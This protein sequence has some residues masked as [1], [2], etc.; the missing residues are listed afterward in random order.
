MGKELNTCCEHFTYDD[1]RYK[2]QFFTRLFW[3]KYNPNGLHRG[4]WS[5]VYSPQHLEDMYKEFMKNE[6]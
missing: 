1:V 3:M 2:R 5:K 6:I 4:I